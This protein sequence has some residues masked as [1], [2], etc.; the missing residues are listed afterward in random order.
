MAVAVLAPRKRK[1]LVEKRPVFEVDINTF[2]II[3]DADANESINRRS[4]WR[5]SRARGKR[6][7]NVLAKLP[8][9]EP[10]SDPGE[11]VPSAGWVDAPE[12]RARVSR[13]VSSQGATLTSPRTSLVAPPLTAGGGR[14]CRTLLHRRHWKRRMRGICQH[15]PGRHR[16]H[17]HHRSHRHL[18]R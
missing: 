10:G 17:R 13:S 11:L 3:D 15:L 4:S 6:E 16:N 5:Y 12:A 8:G 7:D 18:L 9:I 1:S 14:R 2:H